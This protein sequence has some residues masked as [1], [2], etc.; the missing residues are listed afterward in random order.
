MSDGLDARAIALA[1]GCSW[2]LFTFVAGLGS[3]WITS[4]QQ[5]VNWMGQFYVGYAPSFAGSLIGGVWAFFDLFIGLYVFAWLYNYFHA[6][7]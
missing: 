2:A 4:W 7:E 3:M 6:M 1:G 5:A